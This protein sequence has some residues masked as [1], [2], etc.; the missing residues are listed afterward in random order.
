MTVATA[1]R[2]C[3]FLDTKTVDG[4]TTQKACKVV[5]SWMVGVVVTDKRRL[6]HSTIWFRQLVVC[7]RHRQGLQ[8]KDVLSDKVWQKIITGQLAAGHRKPKRGLTELAFKHL[9][10]DV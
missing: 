5:S 2:S 10:L 1:K 4:R 8:L 3:A 7:N 9:R 6:E